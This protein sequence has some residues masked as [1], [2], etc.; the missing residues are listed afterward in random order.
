MKQ[1]TRSIATAAN[2][3]WFMVVGGLCSIV[4]FVAYLYEKLDPKFELLTKGFFGL[5][6]VLLFF[7]YYYS[8]LVRRENIALRSLSRLFYEINEIY[9]SKLQVSFFGENPITNSSDLLDAEKIAL[10]SVCQRIE[11]I[12]STSTNRQCLATVKLV[13]KSNGQG[14]AQTYVRSQELCARDN[15]SRIQYKIGTGENTAFDQALMLN[16]DG[17]PAHFY[18]ADLTKNSNY[19]NQRQ[20]YL[21][22]YK[23]TLVVPIRGERTHHIGEAVEYDLVGFLCVDTLSTNRLN[24]GYQLFMLAALAQQM[25]NFMSLMRGRYTV[26][27]D[28]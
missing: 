3:P 4:G 10:S 8:V 2:N 18:S 23:S 1:S 6:I 14:L 16:A 15:P 22:Y 17:R 28:A 21:S 19:S 13:T 25:Y 24:N 5:G 7:G 12:F 11:N 26:F 27:V 20:H 9:R